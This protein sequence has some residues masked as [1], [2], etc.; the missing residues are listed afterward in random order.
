[1]C[2]GWLTGLG[3]NLAIF[4]GLQAISMCSIETLISLYVIRF[5]GECCLRM[6]TI[7]WYWGSTSS[8]LHIEGRGF[9]LLHSVYSITIASD[10]KGRRASE[11]TNERFAALQ[12]FVGMNSLE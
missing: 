11:E 10:E 5:L 9:W 4:F 3:G 8:D 6:P 7:A 2:S 12:L 1:M